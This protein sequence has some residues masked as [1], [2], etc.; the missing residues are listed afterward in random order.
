MTLP[1]NRTRMSTKLRRVVEWLKAKGLVDVEVRTHTFVTLG[2]EGLEVAAKGLP[3]ARLARFLAA[4]QGATPLPKVKAELEMESQP[5]TP[6]WGGPGSRDGL[7]VERRGEALVASA[8]SPPQAQPAE[9]L[10]KKIA[11]RPTEKRS[12]SPDELAC[13]QPWPSVLPT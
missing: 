11:E 3:E 2:K 7:I 9:E 12:L 13:S 5:S 8:V 4:R 6:R 1:E 10:L